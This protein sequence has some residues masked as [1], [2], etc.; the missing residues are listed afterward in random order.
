M[1][2]VEVAVEVHARVHDGSLQRGL[3]DSQAGVWELQKFKD[4][5]NHTLNPK[6]RNP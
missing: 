6:T 4:M 5:A 2:S 3:P 1:I